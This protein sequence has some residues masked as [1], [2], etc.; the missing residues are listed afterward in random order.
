MPQSVFQAALKL[1]NAD[2]DY[3]NWIGYW[4]LY[5]EF[6]GDFQ[7]DAISEENVFMAHC[8]LKPLNNLILQ[9]IK[10]RFSNHI[11]KA[12]RAFLPQLSSTLV[13]L[14]HHLAVHPPSKHVTILFL[15]AKKNL[16]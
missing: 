10:V 7:G 1:N 12:S 3:E 14:Y 4:K 2:L 6:N 9:W 8:H 5:F 15:D 11:R 16:W 13:P